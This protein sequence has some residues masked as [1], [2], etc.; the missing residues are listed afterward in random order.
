M[1][2][3]GAHYLYFNCPGWLVRGSMRRDVEKPG[4]PDGIP[5]SVSVT[6]IFQQL[7]WAWCRS[8]N[9]RMRSRSSPTAFWMLC[10]AVSCLSAQEVRPASALV[11]PSGGPCPVP[12]G[13]ILGE[14]KVSQ[15]IIKSNKLPPS[16]QEQIAHA[17]EQQVKG[18]SVESVT[19]QALDHAREDLQNRGYFKATAVSDGA[20]LNAVPRQTVSLTIR[21]EEGPR[22]RLGG[23]TFKNN[24]AAISSNALRSLFPIEDGD[25]FSR[26]KIARGLENLRKAYTQFGHINFTSIPDTTFDE[27]KR[28]GFLDIDIDEG[29]QF[30]VRSIDILGVDQATR[31]EILR[32]AP[33]SPG[34]VF[35]SRLLE[36]LIK[37]YPAVFRFAPDDP[38]HIW[39]DLDEHRGTIAITLDARPCGQD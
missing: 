32:D 26:E 13:Q 25:I 1:L 21:V 39:R 35:N 2:P 28:L 34:Q 10:L 17:I 37:H 5:G 7:A 6:G 24:K 19:D 16:T 36:L 18:S 22:Y 38:N 20:T 12:K 31:E 8:Y 4:I 29:M 9:A 27:E 23:I 14:L 3:T 30:Y 11:T 33:L 15:V